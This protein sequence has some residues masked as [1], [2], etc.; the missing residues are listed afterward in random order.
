MCVCFY[1][2][3]VYCNFRKKLFLCI[4]IYIFKQTDTVKP[5]QLIY[6][7]DKLSIIFNQISNFCLLRIWR[8]KT[9]PKK[10]K[11]LALKRQKTTAGAGAAAAK[12]VNGNGEPESDDGQVVNTI[13]KVIVNWN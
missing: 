8:R 11:N 5:G 3:L 7:T 13:Q 10:H 12:L 4:F 9:K 6:K 2:R 1:S